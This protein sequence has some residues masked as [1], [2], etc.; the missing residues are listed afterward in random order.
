MKTKIITKSIYFSLLVFLFSCNE[1]EEEIN[2]GNNFYYI[3][4]QEIIFDVTTFGGNGIYQLENNE[5][6]P[7]ILSDI[8]KYEFNSEFIIV[9]QNFNTEQTSRLIQNMLFMPETYFTYDKK[10]LKLNE[11]Y[12]AKLDES[13][14]N[15]IYSKKFTKE[16]LENTSSLQKMKKNKENYYIIEKKELKINGPLTKSEF[17]EMKMKLEINLSFE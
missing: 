10:Y 6:I 9:E 16:L 17:K 15:S 7:V 8:E 14:N 12:L 11:N 4:F 2:L 3:P 1:S 13:E 5:K